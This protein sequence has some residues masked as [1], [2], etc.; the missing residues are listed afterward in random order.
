MVMNGKLYW[1]NVFIKT[2]YCFMSMSIASGYETIDEEK[3]QDYF[4][5]F[6]LLCE[7]DISS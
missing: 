5:P 1:Q 6:V 3:K 4:F 7:S 2:L